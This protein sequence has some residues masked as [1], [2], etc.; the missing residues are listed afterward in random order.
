MQLECPL[1]SDWPPFPNVR[2]TIQSDFPKIHLVAMAL[3]VKLDRWQGPH[4]LTV[5][6]KSVEVECQSIPNPLVA[7]GT[8]TIQSAA[9]NIEPVVRVDFNAASGRVLDR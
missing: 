6:D 5:P 7:A 3:K 9:R 4:R 8:R 2:L 1:P